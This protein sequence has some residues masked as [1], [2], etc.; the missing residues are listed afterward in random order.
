MPSRYFRDRDGQFETD[1]LKVVLQASAILGVEARSEIKG[2]AALRRASL[3][4]F[5]AFVGASREQ[6]CSDLART[7]IS[8][9]DDSTLRSSQTRYFIGHGL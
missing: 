2:N 9:Q 3:A 4:I 8:F 5:A 6:I 1:H 7:K